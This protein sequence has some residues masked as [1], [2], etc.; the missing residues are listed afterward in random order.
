[1]LASVEAEALTEFALTFAVVE[2]LLLARIHALYI[3]EAV[4]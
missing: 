4:A 3:R 1:M 2:T